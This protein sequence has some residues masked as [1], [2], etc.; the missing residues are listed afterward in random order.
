MTDTDEAIREKRLSELEKENSD[1]TYLISELKD[2]RKFK[3]ETEAYEKIK[4]KIFT[5]LNSLRDIALAAIVIVTTVS[6]FGIYQTG[7]NYIKELITDKFEKEVENQVTKEIEKK[8]LTTKQDL[9]KAKSDVVT[10]VS[11]PEKNTP[12]PSNE[13]KNGRPQEGYV[14]KSFLTKLE[15]ID[16]L[17]RINTYRLNFRDLPNGNIKGRQTE[18]TKVEIVGDNEGEWVNVKVK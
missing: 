2:S 15:G 4:Q 5:W 1:L 3:L 11:S 14:L 10:E 9:D 17:Y 13:S 7:K 6:G 8:Q 18:N 16:N 12:D